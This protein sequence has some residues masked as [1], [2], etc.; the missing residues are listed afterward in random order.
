MAAPGAIAALRRGEVHLV[1]FD[2]T[3]GAE[4]RKTRRSRRR[5]PLS[6]GKDTGA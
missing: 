5:M 3:R 4:I 2:P 6:Q 1:D